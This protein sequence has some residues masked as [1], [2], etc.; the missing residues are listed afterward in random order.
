MVISI[1]IRL[2]CGYCGGVFA[3]L[4][5]WRAELKCGLHLYFFAATGESLQCPTLQPSAQRITL[6]IA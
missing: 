4:S 5:E 6:N 2:E 3:L 1:V